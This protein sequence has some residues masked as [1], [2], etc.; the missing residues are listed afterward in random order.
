MKN[1]E[2]CGKEISY[3]EQY[4]CEECEKKAKKHYELVKEKQKL[5]SV[6]NIIGILAIFIGGFLAM[7]LEI[8]IGL[9][10]IGGGFIL[11]GILYIF[12]PFCTPEQ[13]KKHKI[14]KAVKTV[15]FLGLIIIILGI[16]TVIAG[17][18][19]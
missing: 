5:F 2:Y 3:S 13:I 16:G 18:F 1:C 19:L 14:E 7:M 12:L 11:L 4:C 6:I 17:F 10:C 8:G 15:K 9:Y